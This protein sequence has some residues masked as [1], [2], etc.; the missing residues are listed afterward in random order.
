MAYLGHADRLNLFASVS[1]RHVVASVAKSVLRTLINQH[2]YR[3]Q[4]PHLAG[5]V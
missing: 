5:P 4:V 1:Q 2:T 3:F